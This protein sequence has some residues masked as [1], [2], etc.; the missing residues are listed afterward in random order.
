MSLGDIAI[1]EINL[2]QKD[3]LCMIP[4]VKSDLKESDLEGDRRRAGKAKGGECAL[5]RT[6]LEPQ[7]EE[8]KGSAAQHGCS[9]AELYFRALR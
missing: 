3:K 6:R 5:A 4:F 9:F 1:N 7:D 8:F 2:S